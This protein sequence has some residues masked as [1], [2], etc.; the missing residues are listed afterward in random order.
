[1][2]H[3]SNR[4]LPAMFSNFSIALIVISTD[5]TNHSMSRVRN[6][7]LLGGCR[8]GGA[9]SWFFSLLF[10]GFAL[11]FHSLPAEGILG[12]SMANCGA[13]RAP[14]ADGKGIPGMRCSRSRCSL[15]GWRGHTCPYFPYFPLGFFVVVS[16]RLH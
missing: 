7:L 10:L 14:A 5:C 2:V 6:F 8:E 12:F 1:M 16:P 15:L 3:F 11:L 13:R 9:L 4:I